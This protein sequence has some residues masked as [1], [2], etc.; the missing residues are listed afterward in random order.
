M[1]QIFAE[2]LGREVSALGFGCASLGSRVSAAEGLNAL[3]RAYDQGV[4]WFDVAP[5]YG[6]GAAEALL[7]QFVAGKRDRVAICTKVGIEPPRLSLKA[8]L[9]KPAMRAALKLA[10]QLREAVAHRRP[11][12]IRQPIDA[13]SIEASVTRSLKKLGVDHVDVLA[14]HDPALDD[15]RREDV[16]DALQTMVK[17]GYARIVGIAG[18]RSIAEQGLGAF[19]LYRFIQHADSPLAPPLAAHRGLRVSHSIFGVGGALSRLSQVVATDDGLRTRLAELGF[20]GPSS[21]IAAA[22]LMDFAFSKNENGVVLASMFRPEHAL[23]NI[24]R[25]NRAP[26]PGLVD[27]LQGYDWSTRRP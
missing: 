15:V 23:F 6:D 26:N 22:A 27:L 3:A 24:D 20:T 8:R 21:E 12:S 16:R 11:R 9:L 19:P 7:G 18:D 17:K 4:T 5:P 14:L 1:R 25:A 10:P 2:A 13:Q